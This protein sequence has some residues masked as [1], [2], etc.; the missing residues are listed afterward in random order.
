MSQKL[1]SWMWHLAE[2]SGSLAQKASTTR[3][4]RVPLMRSRRVHSSGETSSLS[5][6]H[7][8]CCTQHGS[9]LA[10]S[11][12]VRDSENETTNLETPLGLRAHSER[13]R[14][15]AGRLLTLGFRSN[16]TDACAHFGADGRRDRFTTIEKRRCDCQC[17][18]GRAQAATV[19]ASDDSPGQAVCRLPYSHFNMHPVHALTNA[20]LISPP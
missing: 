1:S 11:T 4:P 5:K 8:G 20:T 16:R 13:F 9:V 19:L 18:S 14:D 2:A 12:R 17:A 6:S 3:N 7:I 10:A 15:G